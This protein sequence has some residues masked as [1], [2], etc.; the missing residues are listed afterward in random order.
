[1]HKT[2]KMIAAAVVGLSLTG[3]AA[4]AATGSLP[5]Q[6]D[7]GV[8]TAG[9]HAGFSVPASQDDHPTASDHPDS[10]DD[11]TE[12]SEAPTTDDS[13]SSSHPDNHGAAVSA[14][15]KSTDTTGSDHGAAVS[16]VARDNNGH[17]QP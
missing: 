14:V 15:A 12:S 3:G 11:S 17:S 16:A 8:T 10:T 2:S 5:S 9:D 7:H 4:A 13:T 1:M 6:A